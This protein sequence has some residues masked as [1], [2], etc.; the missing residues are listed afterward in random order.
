MERLE[1]TNLLNNIPWIVF[2]DYYPRKEPT[3]VQK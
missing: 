3:Y 2:A 1:K